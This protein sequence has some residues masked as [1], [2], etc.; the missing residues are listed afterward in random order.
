[1]LKPDIQYTIKLS[2]PQHY[3]A[4]KADLGAMEDGPHIVRHQTKAPPRTFGAPP[5]L[6]ERFDCR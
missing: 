3:S 2:K 6:A 5:R 4:A 1:M